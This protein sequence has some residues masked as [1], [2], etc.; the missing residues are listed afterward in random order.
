MKLELGHFST[1]YG[2]FE[3]WPS[4]DHFYSDFDVGIF[5]CGLT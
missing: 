5:M 4:I 1:P 2:F 3:F